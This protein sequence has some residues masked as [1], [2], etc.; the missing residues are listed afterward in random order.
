MSE[1][2]ELLEQY[3]LIA[4]YVDAAE[5]QIKPAKESL[6]NIKEALLAKMNELE[7]NSL[8]SIAG[9]AVAR[10]NSSSAKVVDAEAFYDFVFETGDTSFLTKHVSKDAV[11]EYLKATNTLP[12]G[13]AS[14]STTTIR[15]TRAK[16]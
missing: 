15:F 7:L 11:E 6:A 2:S 10:V 13:V 5:A 4:D 3:V 8:K 1:V 9:H 16:K 12:P 14:E